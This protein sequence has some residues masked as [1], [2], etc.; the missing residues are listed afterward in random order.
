MKMRKLIPYILL[1]FV[2]ASC[3]TL[4]TVSIDYLLP[5][6]VSFPTSIKTIGV[7]NNT[8]GSSS[9]RDIKQLNDNNSV[10]SD[11]IVTLEGD[12]KTATEEL[13]NN[14]ANGNYFESVIICDSVLRANDLIAREPKLGKEEVKELADNLNVDVI[15]ALEQI[16]LYL[17]K[18]LVY[19]PEIPFPESTIDATLHTVARIYLPNRDEPLVTLSDTDSIYWTGTWNINEG[20]I[21]EASAFAATLP[22]RHILPTWKNVTRY[23][24]AGESVEM[25]DAVV[26]I[27]ENSW[28][29]A[30]ALWKTVYA[31]KSEKGKM[32]AAHNIALYYEMKDD[33]EEAK[34]WLEKALAIAEKKV[35]KNEKGEVVETTS[36]YTLIALYYSDLMTR[37]GNLSKLNIQ[38][39]RFNGDF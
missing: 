19:Y 20:M 37:I 7:V 15:L 36:D 26:C 16:R 39:Q 6:D 25:R 3:R 9:A 12:G 11:V 28:D 18:G 22:V 33:L 2:F 27:R 17:K 10:Y 29:E 21:K 23:Y 24:Y 14:V 13:A 8:L 4:D 35:K 1:L 38:M 5:S 34:S 30:L 31:K 32:R